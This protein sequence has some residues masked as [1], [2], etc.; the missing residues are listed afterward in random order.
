MVQEVTLFYTPQNNHGCFGDEVT[1]QINPD[2]TGTVIK[3]ATCSSCWQTGCDGNAR[4][5]VGDIVSLP[6]HSGSWHSAQEEKEVW[7]ADISRQGSTNVKP[8]DLRIL[9]K[10]K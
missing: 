1:I 2:N 7:Q 6:E 4:L 3:S 10:A 8:S 9:V 5:K